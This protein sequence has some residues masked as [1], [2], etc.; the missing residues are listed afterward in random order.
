MYL[1]INGF[2]HDAGA[3][4]IDEKGKIIAAVEE[5][6]FTG[7]K[8]ESRF[9][10]ESIKYCLKEAKITTLQLKG[11]GYAWKPS[12]L[13][14]QR[15]L[16]SN[17]FSYRVPLAN[18]KK[19]FKKFLNGINLKK[20]FEKEIGPL[21]KDIKISYFKH[22]HAHV[23]SAFFASHFNE[24][25]FLT[26]DGR[27]EME[28]G[29]W[30]TV[31]GTKIT[32]KGSIKYPDSLGNF[33]VAIGHF[34]GFPSFFKAGTVM[35]LAAMGKPKYEKEFNEIIK[36]DLTKNSNFIK[37]NKD[38]IDCTSGDG[39]PK[40]S[41]EELFKIPIR[42]PNEELKQEYKDIAA[43][44]QKIVQDFILDL[45]TK[46][47]EN[48]KKD[49]LVLSGGV[50]LNSVTNGL[51]KER[52]PFK[53]FFIQPAA[54]DAGLC[55]GAAYLMLHSNKTNKISPEMKSA[56]LGPSYTDKEILVSIKE[57]KEIKYEKKE[58][59]SRIAA[60]LVS[61]GY[62][63]GWF[64]GRLEFGPRA[65]GNRS[66][67][68]DPRRQETVREL[69]IIKNRESFRPFAVS[70]IKE[71]TEKWMKRG[72]TSP[73]MLLVDYVK[74]NLKKKVPAA[75]HYDGSVRIQ[76]VTKNE[77]GIYY[78]LIDEFYKITH[79]PMIINTSFNIEGKPIV[80]TPKEAIEAFLKVDLDALC[81]GNYLVTKK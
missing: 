12:S 43:T 72:T 31:E 47:Y 15:I 36:I 80:R 60:Q 40:K 68:A 22:H 7:N 4:I 32:K 55:I 58:K 51:I 79:I 48:T 34:C 70:I 44:M 49:Y 38:Y 16:L 5:E 11:V 64:N 39:I 21:Q 66:I 52:T 41:M 28:T 63:I 54:H 20:T 75:Q 10:T 73:F 1:G 61:K 23:G 74:D 17:L 30:G 62:K 14:F 18:I 6:R 65:L 46:I 57:F 29:T 19:S 2:S 27:G 45:L 59:I 56:S 13:L 69:N 3:C 42:N 53:D 50:C 76:T 33:Y 77:N 78:D 9:P 35:A 25:A 26:L 37:L 67:L 24:A 8:H 81:I 71:E